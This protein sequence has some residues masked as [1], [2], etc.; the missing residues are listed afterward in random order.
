MFDELGGVTNSPPGNEE[1]GDPMAEI[2]GAAAEQTVTTVADAV[3]GAL[4]GHLVE[5]VTAGAKVLDASG[6][7]PDPRPQKQAVQFLP[8]RLD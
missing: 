4:G 7:S 2:A 5:A 6:G 1:S 3:V 8:V